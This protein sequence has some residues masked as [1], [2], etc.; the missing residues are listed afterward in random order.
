[1]AEHR[2]SDLRFSVLNYGVAPGITLP[3]KTIH[4]ELMNISER[5]YSGYNE[6]P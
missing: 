6:I 3:L 5:N 1:V 2:C 4:P